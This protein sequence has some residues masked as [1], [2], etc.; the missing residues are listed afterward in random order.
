MPIIHDECKFICRLSMIISSNEQ[1]E[2]FKLEMETLNMIPSV[3]A[4]SNLHGTKS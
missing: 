2:T 1:I 4:S 3:V